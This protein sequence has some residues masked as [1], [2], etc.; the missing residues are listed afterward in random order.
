MKEQRTASTNQDHDANTNSSDNY[1]FESWLIVDPNQD[2][3]LALGLE[4]LPAG[5]W[6]ASYKIEDDALWARI[7][8]GEV[9][10]FSLEG[11]FEYAPAKETPP[12]PA[13]ALAAVAPPPPTPQPTPTEMAKST[14][15]KRRRN[16]MHAAWKKIKGMKAILAEALLSKEFMDAAREYFADYEL[17]DGTGL[18]VDDET[19]AAMLLDAEGN[20]T[21]P[22]PDGTHT[23]GGTFAGIV[24]EV[25]EG[26]LTK[27]VDE[28][29]AG[30]SAPAASPIEQTSAQSEL[31]AALERIA[32]L[33]AKLAP[34]PAVEPA[35]PSEQATDKVA[36]LEAQLAE[37]KAQNEKLAKQPAVPPIEKDNGNP[38]GA[39][40]E[41][42]PAHQRFLSIAKELKQTA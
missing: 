32:A 3:S 26:K 22:A 6:M 38:T 25:V 37:V 24:I 39:P 42:L 18:R 33:E 15:A 8:A 13:Q 30:D 9:L 5:T 35:K 36:Q 29:E 27:P 20:P 1:L 19:L 34:P 23:L 40:A 14:L 4:P 2:K 7:E 41:K 21:G 12:T 28:I 31:A 11:V 10:G 16:K 17:E